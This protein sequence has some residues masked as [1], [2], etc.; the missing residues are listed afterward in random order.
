MCQMRRQTTG[1]FRFGPSVATLAGDESFGSFGD[2]VG[3]ERAGGEL[4]EYEAG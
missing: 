4:G 1:R 2:V 3:V